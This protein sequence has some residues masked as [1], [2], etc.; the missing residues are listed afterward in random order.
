MQPSEVRLWWTKARPT[1]LELLPGLVPQVDTEAV[2]LDRLLQRSTETVLC[3]LG[4]SGIGKSTLINAIV[5]EGK[6]I[7]PAGGTGPLTA[8][9]TRVRFNDQPYFRV[10]YQRPAKLRGILLSLEGELFRR[11]QLSAT[12]ALPTDVLDQ[13]WLLEEEDRGDLADENQAASPPPEGP[14]SERMNVM[15]HAAQVLV[16]GATAEYVDRLGL[17]TALRFAL[18]LDYRGHIDEADRERLRDIAEALSFAKTDSWRTVRQTSERDIFASLLEKHTAG[19]LAPL[20]AE[21][22]VGWPSP[23]LSGGVVLVDLPGVGIAGDDYQQATHTYVRQQARGVIIVIKR[24]I[25]QDEIDLIRTSGLWER[26]LLASGDPDADPCDLIIVRTSVDEV[27]ETRVSDEADDAEV[28]DVYSSVIAEA[29]D[30]VRRQA[31]AEFR[32]LSGLETD[33]AELRE[34]REKTVEDVVARLDIHPV[35]AVDYRKLANRNQRFP[36]VATNA[37]QTGIPALRKRLFELGT[38]NN[39]N[40]DRLRLELAE[41]IAAMAN[42]ALDQELAAL[43]DGRREKEELDRLRDDLARFLGPKRVEYANR[44][45]EFREFLAV[46]A[47]LLIDRLVEKAR[48]DAQKSV[49]R[50]LAELS[51]APWATLRAAVVRGGAFH[52]KR[53]IDLADDIAQL[54]QEPVAAIWGSKT[55]LLKEIRKRTYEFGVITQE[56][57]GESLDWG[58]QQSGDLAFGDSLDATRRAAAALSDQLGQVGQDASDDLRRAVRDRLLEV[59]KPAI[60]KACKR[61]VERGDAAGPGVKRRM[62]GLFADLAEDSVDRAGSVATKLLLERFVGVRGDISAVFTQWGDPF[63]AIVNAIAPHEFTGDANKRSELSHRL[64]SLRLGQRDTAV[65]EVIAT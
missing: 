16:K 6:A 54:F 1:F 40:L 10:R 8:I 13:P 17:S 53:K 9:A 50:Y 4:Q 5:A 45:G 15:L 2:R 60:A 33:D 3:F 65:A 31:A 35:S 19:S 55:G 39:A 30:N 59:T 56:L 24:G 21:I 25:T 64:Q 36:A 41:R 38:Q 32:R 62:V 7:L 44:Q 52:G 27:V 29:S 58:S 12:D 47:T 11:G 28:A 34:A 14:P 18:G 23:A 51:S 26:M 37:E 20:V 61:F 57:I 49:V 43:A 48:A 22:E 63:D 42:S 46:T